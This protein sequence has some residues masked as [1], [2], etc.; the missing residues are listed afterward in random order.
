MLVGVDFDNTIVCYDQVFHR[1]AVEWGLIP[2]EVPVAKGSIRDYLRQ[3]G[4]EEAWIELQGY[5]YGV[6]MRDALP[7]PG[8]LG[9][10]TRCKRHDIAVC[11]ISHRT[12]HPF[13]GP[14]CDLHQAGHEW[15]EQ[16]GFYDPSGISLSPHQVHFE[17]TKGEKLDRIAGAGCTHFIDDLPEFLAV[18]EFPAGVQRILFDPNHCH[19]AEGRFHR[20][21][22]W[23]E[24]SQ[25]I[26][27]GSALA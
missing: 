3:R 24:I 22:S 23:T 9:F 25:F 16:H 19:A 12:R 2:A 15:L 14:S 13:R 6:R 10:F 7:F 1:V 20:A 26:I 4:K 5:V 21:A 8:V 11:V 27:G 17:L 18:P